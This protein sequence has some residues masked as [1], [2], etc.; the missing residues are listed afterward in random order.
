M[1]S[2]SMTWD[3]FL[4][5][6]MAV[7]KAI[8]T[9]S[10]ES[11]NIEESNSIIIHGF[12]ES[13]TEDDIKDHFNDKEVSGE[14]NISTIQINKEEGWCMVEFTKS[15]GKKIYSKGMLFSS[16]FVFLKFI[17]LQDWSRF[18]VFDGIVNLHCFLFAQFKSERG[19]EVISKVYN[20]TPPTKVFSYTIALNY[21][22]GY[23]VMSHN[24][25]EVM[26]AYRTMVGLS[27]LKL[28]V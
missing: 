2:Y 13:T 6:A 24:H 14:E 26:L 25:V 9:G 3:F 28:F 17:V 19:N 16:N 1:T 7:N 22:V 12:S 27:L 20:N 4:L 11:L 8:V 21:I 5:I 10:V 23:E 15:Q 18:T